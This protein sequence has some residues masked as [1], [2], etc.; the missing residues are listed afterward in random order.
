MNESAVS[1]TAWS[2]CVC[3]RTCVCAHCGYSDKCN[4]HYN[5]THRSLHSPHPLTL[6]PPA[7]HP[8]RPQH[9][10]A[11]RE[12]HHHLLTRYFALAFYP[13]TAAQSWRCWSCYLWQWAAPCLLLYPMHLISDQCS[14]QMVCGCSIRGRLSRAWW[15]W[16]PGGW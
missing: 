8:A 14:G 16:P 13:Y 15:T 4:C 10:S 7:V 3:M 11:E 6:T 9:L 1:N 5:H 12:K 2:V